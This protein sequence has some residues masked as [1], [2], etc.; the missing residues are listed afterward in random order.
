MTDLADALTTLSRQLPPGDG[1]VDFGLA[2]VRLIRNADAG[3]PLPMAYRPSLCL[4][5]Q[6]EKEVA[7]GSRVIRLGPGQVLT[8]GIELPTVG[9]ILSAPLLG[10]AIDLEAALI[11]EL[12]EGMHLDG[13]A[14]AAGAAPAGPELMEAA[15]RLARLAGREDALRLLAPGILREIHFWALAGPGH[16][17]LL[18]LARPQGAAARLTRAMAL[19]GGGEGPAIPVAELAAAAG[20][21]PSSFHAHFRDFTGLSPLQYQKELRLHAARR[22]LLAGQGSAAS[23]AH[24]VGYE[25]ASQFSRDYARLF[26]APPARAVAE[27]RRIAAEGA[28]EQAA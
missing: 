15:A 9:R 6:G 3:A 20:M 18:T 5:A 28:A 19:I 22:R 11:A 16:G 2:G 7:S 26:G 12:A 17:A 25:S 27:E 1:A 21:S 14:A 13:A 8:V 23:I 10:L 24:A 4:I